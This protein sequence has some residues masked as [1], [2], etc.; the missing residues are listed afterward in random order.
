MPVAARVP[1]IVT[2]FAGS[3]YAGEAP[4]QMTSITIE[5]V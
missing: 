2:A 5:I 4:S 3:G 1:F